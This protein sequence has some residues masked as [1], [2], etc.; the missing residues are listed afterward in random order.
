MIQL[1]SVM[2]ALRIPSSLLSVACAFAAQTKIP[3]IVVGWPTHSFLSPA[4]MF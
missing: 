1:I 4:G 3:G 2:G